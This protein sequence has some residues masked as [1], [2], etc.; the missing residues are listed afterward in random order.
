VNGYSPKATRI[1]Q[2]AENLKLYLSYAVTIALLG[3]QGLASPCRKFTAGSPD[4][5]DIH[6]LAHSDISSVHAMLP[7]GW[8]DSV[9]II[10]AYITT[11]YCFPIKVTV[12]GSMVGMGVAILHTDTAWLAH[13]LVHPAHRNR[14]IGKTITETLVESAYSKGCETIYLLATELGEP[15]YRSIGFETETEYP[16]YT[17]K[18]MTRPFTD[19]EHIVPITDAYKEQVLNLDRQATGEDRMLVLNPHLS[20]GL[21]YLRDNEVQGFYL[22]ALR[23]GLII[24]STNEAGQELMRLRL[25]SNDSASFP[26]DNTSAIAFMQQHGFPENRREKRM[27]LGKKRTWHPERIY[28]MIGGN[29]G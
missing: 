26:M 20:N 28:G 2:E 4:Q 9:P 8:E 1:W 18:G 16:I 11:P 13:I 22:P 19:S 10:D 23:H 17:C 25:Q 3:A 6:P 27:R 5:M 24:A 29:L 14:G 15:V 7:F 21:I 12:G